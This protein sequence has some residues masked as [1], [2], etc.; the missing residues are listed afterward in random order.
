MRSLTAEEATAAPANP[1]ASAQPNS[2]HVTDYDRVEELLNRCWDELD[3]VELNV[4]LTDMIR[5]L[6]F[7]QKLATTANAERD[8][9]NLIDTIRRDELA[10]FG[11]IDDSETDS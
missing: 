4:K 6:E 3:G 1:S 8:F 11:R 10:D 5:L 7:K 2:R 9:W